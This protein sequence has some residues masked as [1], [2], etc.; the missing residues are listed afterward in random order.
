MIAHAAPRLLGPQ[1]KRT[2]VGVKMIPKK[3]THPPW[4]EPKQTCLG[5]SNLTNQKTTTLSEA[6]L[7]VHSTA[8]T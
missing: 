5:R 8:V 2:S 3:A 6:F 7:Q 4:E 1:R